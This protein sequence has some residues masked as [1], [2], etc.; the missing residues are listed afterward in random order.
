M[1]KHN[2]LLNYEN[3]KKEMVEAIQKAED[4]LKK[5]KPKP[6]VK[7][8]WEE[9]KKQTLNTVSEFDKKTDKTP[10]E[11]TTVGILMNTLDNLSSAYIQDG[12]TGAPV[13][14]QTWVKEMK[15]NLARF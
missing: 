6:F 1:V 3:S 11:Y 12:A 8:E 4:L 14:N 7:K 5:Y 9:L 13:L 2:R 10:S 15:K